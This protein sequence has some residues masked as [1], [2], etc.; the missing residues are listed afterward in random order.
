MTKGEMSQTPQDNALLWAGTTM[1]SENQANIKD[2]PFV[3]YEDGHMKATNAT[4]N[5][6][7]YATDGSFTGE[8]HATSG[9]FTGSINATE[10]K[11]GDDQEPGLVV[12]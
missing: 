11:T 4:I 12:T 3:V 7:V 5:G 1:T 2:A 9:S 6:T 8:V 10:F